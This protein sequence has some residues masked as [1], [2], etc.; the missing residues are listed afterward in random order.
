MILEKPPDSKSVDDRRNERCMLITIEV[1]CIEVR[2]P[3]REMGS[4][5]SVYWYV[6]KQDYLGHG[7]CV[8][9]GQRKS[10]E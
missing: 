2:L 4:I 1:F 8:N 3:Y 9:P 6:V 7:L 5:R 10:C